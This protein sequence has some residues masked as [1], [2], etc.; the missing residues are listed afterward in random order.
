MQALR[1][2]RKPRSPFV[3]ANVVAVFLV[4]DSFKLKPLPSAQSALQQGQ[5]FTLEIVSARCSPET[6]VDNLALEP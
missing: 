1:L 6:G 3:R 2:H 4:V 5:V